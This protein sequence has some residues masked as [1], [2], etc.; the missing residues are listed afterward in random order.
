[1][2]EAGGAGQ[3]ADTA[4][5][6]RRPDQRRAARGAGRLVRQP[7]GRSPTISNQQSAISNQIASS[8]WLLITDYCHAYRPWQCLNFLP[9]PH[10]HSSLRP[11]LPQLAGSCGLRAGVCGMRAGAAAGPPLPG[12]APPMPYC[13][14]VSAPAIASAISSSPVVGSI[15]C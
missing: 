14:S 12:A 3:C 5:E 15:L 11:T 2:A 6:R 7:L 4:C 8:F 1:K 10:G 13:A 9:E